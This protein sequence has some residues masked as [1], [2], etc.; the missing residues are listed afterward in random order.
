MSF[1]ILSKGIHNSE[2]N[3]LTITLG[4]F[5]SKT[6]DELLLPAEPQIN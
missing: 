4:S 2:Y 6:K 1:I 5:V 3:D